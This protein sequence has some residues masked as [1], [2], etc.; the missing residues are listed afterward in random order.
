MGSWASEP[1]S[2]HI[3][4]EA[5]SHVYNFL[6]DYIHLYLLETF[7][8]FFKS[9][10]NVTVFLVYLD[11]CFNIW[12]LTQCQLTEVTQCLL[13]E[14]VIDGHYSKPLLDASERAGVF[15]LFVPRSLC[16]HLYNVPATFHYYPSFSIKLWF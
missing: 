9:R 13:V 15:V 2:H 3:A 14:Q 5:F 10:L 1:L 4:S 8:I 12:L 11:Y 7:F 6:L 16:S